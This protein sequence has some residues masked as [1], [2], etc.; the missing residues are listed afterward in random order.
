MVL[1]I[2]VTPGLA[3]L[4]LGVSTIK[5][6]APPDLGLGLLAACARTP[7]APAPPLRH[8]LRFL[9]ECR[10][11]MRVSEYNLRFLTGQL[12]RQTS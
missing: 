8:L 11:A 3:F 4:L 6:L 1:K 5:A 9:H 12:S 10:D 7:P 2:K